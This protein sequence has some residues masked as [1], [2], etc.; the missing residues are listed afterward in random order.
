MGD[1]I[2]GEQDEFNKTLSFHL[3]LLRGAKPARSRLLIM[4]K[5]NDVHAT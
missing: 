5:S 2:G 4:V 3:P 1:T